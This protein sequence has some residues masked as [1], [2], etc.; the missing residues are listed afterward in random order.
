MIENVFYVL[1]DVFRNLIRGLL[2]C[3]LF[4]GLVPVKA[5]FAVRRR[6][7]ELGLAGQ[8]FVFHMAVSYIAPLRQFLYGGMLSPTSS[9]LSIFPLI[10]S[11]V[12]CLL[13]SLCF[14]EGFRSSSY[15]MLT[16]YTLNELILFI[17]HMPFVAANNLIMAMLLRMVTNGNMFIIEHFNIIMKIIQ[18]VFWNLLFQISFLLCLWFSVRVLRQ[19]LFLERRILSR[20]QQLYLAV[21]STMGFCFCIML[22]SILYFTSDVQT[23]MITSTYP[24][25]GV[26][27]PLISFMCLV[28]LLLSAITL[29]RLVVSSEKEILVEIY[30]NRIEDM[31]EHMRDMERLYDGI[32]GMR[33]DM[34]NY[35]ADMEL[36]LKRS[37]QE[38]E[39]SREEMHRYL[40]GLCNALEELDMKCNTGNPV[41]DVVISRKMRTAEKKQ[42]PFECTFL[43]PEGMGISAFDIS[44][45]LNNG[46]DNALE[47]AEAKDRIWLESYV[48]NNM[49]FIEIRNTFSGEIAIDETGMNLHTLKKEDAGHGYGLKNIKS[50]AEK[51]YGRADWQI[52]NHSQDQ[53]ETARE[54]FILTVMLQGKKS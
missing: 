49:L 8:F 40:D 34:K 2:L 44:I 19:N 22:R 5:R 41:T 17:L 30:Q 54:L 53:D 9:R 24:E 18:A 7:V 23:E 47:A 37:A 45:I 48:Q 16:F 50:C 46:L 6:W 42:V 29:K 4:H 52:V 11:F 15:L 13:Y 39:L 12:L 35:V 51:Y 26:L 36:L 1:I 38:P 33:H 28:L 31:E 3:W 14:Y 20:N 10:I 21:P 27:I 32:R 43:Y 25:T